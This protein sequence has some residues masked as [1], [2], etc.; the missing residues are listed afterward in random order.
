MTRYELKP[1]GKFRKDLKR[2]QKRGY[3]LALMKRVLDLLADGKTLPAHYRDH[4]LQGDLS[5]C[6][7]SHIT[8]DWL[9]IYRVE[10]DALLLL[11]MRTGS[12]SDLF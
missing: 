7:E 9:L 6:R 5:G 8:P 12:H 10:E 4:A 2:I 3:D 1:S 11:L